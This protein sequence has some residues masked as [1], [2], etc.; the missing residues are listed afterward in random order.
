[1]GFIYIV[2]TIV[3]TVYGQLVIKWQMNNAGEFPLDFG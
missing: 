3:F 1:M 2:L